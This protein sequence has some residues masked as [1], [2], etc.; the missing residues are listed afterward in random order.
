MEQLRRIESVEVKQVESAGSK[1]VGG[2]IAVDHYD[3]AAAVLDSA[4]DESVLQVKQVE[5]EFVTVVTAPMDS[6]P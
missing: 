6:D 1:D 3:A 5:V 4:V 2:E